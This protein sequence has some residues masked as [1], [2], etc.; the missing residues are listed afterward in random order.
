M[1]VRHY[2]IVYVSFFLPSRLSLADNPVDVVQSVK[3]GPV[4]STGRGVAVIGLTSR[5]VSLRKRIILSKAYMKGY[6]SLT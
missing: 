4:E 1:L 3:T 6:S 5:I 2:Y